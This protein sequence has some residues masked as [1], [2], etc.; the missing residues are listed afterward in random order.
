MTAFV[1]D[2]THTPDGSLAFDTPTVAEQ[3]PGMRTVSDADFAA[4]LRSDSAITNIL[5]ETWAIVDGVR[6]PFFWSTNGYTTAGTSNPLFYAPLIAAS[7]PFEEELSLKSAASLSAGD[8]EIDNTNGA[9]EAY[10]SYIWADEIV[11]LVGDQTWAR[12]DY[13]LIFVGHTAGLVRKGTRAF[14]LRLRDM[15]EGLN[16]PLSERKFG[17]T[18]PNADLLIPNTF[19]EC[20]NASGEWSDADILERQWHDGPIEGVNE[21]RASGIP[22]T[23]QVTVSEGTG[24]AILSVNNETATVTAT[25]QGDK[26]GGVFRKTI[27]ALVQ[28]FITGYGKYADR[29]TLANI[30]AANF[31]AFDAAHQQEVGLHVRESLNV[32]DAC[33]MLASSVGAQLAPSLDGKLQLIQIALP[34]AGV[35]TEIR[36]EHMISGSLKHVEHIDPVAAV[37]LG[38]SKNWTPQPGLQT[39]IPAAHKAL[40]EKEWPLTVTRTSKSIAQDYKLPGDATMRPTMLLRASH[41]TAEADR[42]NALWGPGRDIYEFDGVP[43]LL[44]LQKGARLIVYHEQ[45][46]M[47]S[48]VEAQVLKVK[49]NWWTRTVNVRFLK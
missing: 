21:V 35:A 41:A 24:R 44:M 6:T 18:G 34:A 26:F 10:A 28:R 2:T 11:A 9:N 14:A 38:Y 43:D 15:M 40:F 19:G 29:Y 31:A 12:A 49:R 48:G 1:F 25:V 42:L 16:Y 33:D 27:A 23:E 13:R 17:G 22:I 30:D 36:A 7:I 20:C 5:V 39:G 3:Q 4:W 45:D 8:F 47:A 46:G 32:I 37:K